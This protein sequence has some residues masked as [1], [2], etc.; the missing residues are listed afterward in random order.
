MLSG[1][2]NGI[3]TEVWNPE[4]RSAEFAVAASVDRTRRDRA[5]NKAALQH[6]FGLAPDADAPSVR[7]SISRMAWQKGL[8]LLA[9]A[10][11]ALLARGAQLAVLGTGDRRAGTALTRSR[12]TTRQVGC[13]IGYDEDVAHLIQAGADAV[14]VPRA[15]SRAA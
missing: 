14:L 8:D 9:E 7:A 13:I 12:P 3:D 1:I 10:M 2:L 6:R 5:P 11:P 15:S 4:D